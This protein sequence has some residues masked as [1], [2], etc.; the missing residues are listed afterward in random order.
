MK[1]WFSSLPIH[2]KLTALALGVSAAALLAAVL[3]LT[4][5]D[6]ARFRTSA[7]DDAHALAQVI[8]ENMAAA[9]V[10]DDAEAAKAT[11]S[12]VRVRPTVV[13][14][15]VYRPNKSVLAS[16]ARPGA[17]ACPVAPRVEVSWGH[18][19]SDAE[20]QQNGRVVGT[21]FVERALSDLGARVAA[22]A[23]AGIFV[24][25][26]GGAIALGLARSLQGIVS[27]PIVSL[28]QAARSI[29]RDQ[30]YELPLIEASPDETGDLVRAFGDM[31]RRIGEANVA[32][33]QSN[34][35]LR[36]EVEQ[37]RRMEGEREA[38]LARER[39]ASRLKDE[40]LAAVS[41]ELRTPLNAILGWTQILQS[42]RPSPQTV[43]RAIAS[44]A[45]NA[46]AQNRV[47]E[48]LL[49]I[50]RIITGKLQ[51]AVAPVDLRVAIEDA[52]EVTDPIAASRQIVVA[53]E[54]PRTPCVVQGD[55][56]RLRQVLWNLLS[57]ALKFTAPGGRVQVRLSETGGTYEIAVADTGIG[58][59]GTFLSHVFE[60]FRQADGS[61]TREQ[62]GLGLGL[63]IVKELTEL[64]GGTVRA[65]SPGAGRG[66]TFTIS[67]PRSPA[68]RA[69]EPRIA[70]LEETVP[71]LD[72]IR[73]LVVDDNADS[74]EVIAMALERAGASV[75]T[76]LSGGG[77]VAAWEHN[78]A[79]VLLCDLAMPGIDGFE[80][81]RRIRAIDGKPDT[82]TPALAIT[83]YASDEDRERCMRAGFVGH[84]S[85]PYN[86]ADVV[87]A[88]ADAAA[89]S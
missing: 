8:A 64:H 43:S 40:F 87:R 82:A 30:K 25:I 3:G 57:N 6:L 41:H 42:T 12:S 50:S 7:A 29:G 58:I 21:V 53:L 38:L 85:K 22:T 54:V 81:L 28:A 67:L 88:V 10:F 89:H 69:S 73:V 71:R 24:L 15:C 18:V 61:T 26:V 23:G 4:V 1:R 55:Y 51:L 2:R 68:A 77:A 45:R 59:A 70:S 32:L 35:A 84:L 39:E 66:A 72:G 62:G 76:E 37:R 47:I 48:D 36:G 13:M 16:F 11:L 80:V 65:E 79:D 78:P 56:D 63:A 74:L 44:L 34:T 60:R 20:V 17:G 52:I 75:R 27:R 83:A 14:A 49:D 5:L 9:L 19:T 31:V 86:I 33:V 46:Q